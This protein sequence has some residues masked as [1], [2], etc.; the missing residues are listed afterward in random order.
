MKRTTIIAAVVAAHLIPI[1]AWTKPLEAW[2]G[3]YEA[4][5]QRVGPASIWATT[6][7]HANR[8]P[9]QRARLGSARK[10]NHFFT[11]GCP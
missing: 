7:E 11:K 8:S 6:E 9:G 4:W 3:Q 5:E 1:L 10:L 2:R